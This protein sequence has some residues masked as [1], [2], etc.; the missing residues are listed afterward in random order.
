MFPV[1]PGLGGPY[2][3]SSVISSAW[4]E[5]AKAVLYCQASAARACSVPIELC[6]SHLESAGFRLIRRP[7]PSGFI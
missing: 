6:I 5:R 4:R 3:D 1:C 7:Q 2:T